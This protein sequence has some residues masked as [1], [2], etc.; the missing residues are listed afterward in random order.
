MLNPH[1]NININISYNMAGEKH[2]K[3]TAGRRSAKPSKN[4][5]TLPAEP[6]D[7]DS[8][9]RK[10]LE[11]NLKKANEHRPPEGKKHKK[12]PSAI[13]RNTITP[14]LF[15][16]RRIKTEGPSSDPDQ[17]STLKKEARSRQ[18]YRS[19]QPVL[20]KTHAGKK[21]ALN[22]SAKTVKEAHV[23]S[24]SVEGWRKLPVGLSEHVVSQ[25]ISGGKK[26]RAHSTF[27]KND[28]VVSRLLNISL[29]ASELGGS[30]PITSERRQEQPQSK[31]FKEEMS[32]IDMRIIR[33][34]QDDVPVF[35]QKDAH[36]DVVRAILRSRGIS[37]EVLTR[38]VVF[39]Q[40]LWRKKQRNSVISK[41]RSLFQQ[42]TNKLTKQFG[43]VSEIAP[44][45]ELSVSRD[46]DLFTN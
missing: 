28:K 43:E 29:L 13:H 20:N 12:K 17:G 30:R 25:S 24:C 10:N 23:N 38:K 26:R 31:T 8:K 33:S 16:D 42:A 39:I 22:K 9:H 2:N 18:H 34:M 11:N 37:L 1:H 15:I 6:N 21:S 7:I 45:E 41:Y 36:P 4:I 32:S 40:R 5:Y 3:S 35:R 27:A 46:F 14:D 19:T 44:E